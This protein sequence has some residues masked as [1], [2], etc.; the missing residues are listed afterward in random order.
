MT[1]I[2]MIKFRWSTIFSEKAAEIE[3]IEAKTWKKRRVQLRR[4]F[5]WRNSADFTGEEA[6]RADPWKKALI[7]FV[8]SERVFL[9]VLK[10]ESRKGKKRRV[11]RFSFYSCRRS[12]GEGNGSIR[13]SM[14]EKKAG[15]DNRSSFVGSEISF[16]FTIISACFTV[17]VRDL[18]WIS[19]RTT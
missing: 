10:G 1:N 15:K 7:F 2:P 12:H 6:S 4:R 5:I 11:T 17:G 9:G 18:L 16:A 3:R 14:S 8:P 13:E 19:N